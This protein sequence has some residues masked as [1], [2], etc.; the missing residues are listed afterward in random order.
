MEPVELKRIEEG[1]SLV[2]IAERQRPIPDWE[3]TSRN[4]VIVTFIVLGIILLISVVLYTRLCPCFT[5]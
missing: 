1:L 5:K 3:L 2:S 4:G